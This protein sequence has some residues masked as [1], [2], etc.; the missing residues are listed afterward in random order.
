MGMASVS[1]DS[2]SF[3]RDESP[4]TG[5]IFTSTPGWAFISKISFIYV[6]SWGHDKL[7]YPGTCNLTVPLRDNLRAKA[8]QGAKT[9]KKRRTLC[10]CEK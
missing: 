10:K 8:E 3:S 1:W 2:S 4:T 6:K 5:M 9:A 7:S